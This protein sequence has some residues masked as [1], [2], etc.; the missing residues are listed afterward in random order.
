MK[1][2]N[3]IAGRIFWAI[4]ILGGAVLLTL[5]A[6]GIGLES[7]PVKILGSLLLVGVAVS[8][9]V[10]LRFFFAALPL[11]GIAAIW[12]A[13]LGYP[14]MN[15]WLVL[16]A[17]ALLGIALSILF[18]RKHDWK[19]HLHV[20]G[21]ADDDDDDSC[22]GCK[23]VTGSAGR[24]ST[25]TLDADETVDIESRFGEQ[26]KYI[27]SEHLKRVTLSASFAEVK[28]YFDQCKVHPD[29]LTI[30]VS[31][32]FCGI[33]LSLPKDWAVENRISVFAGAVNESGRE[34]APSA[35]KVTLVGS[36]NFG[37]IKVH[38]V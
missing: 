36:L 8:S 35:G 28:A 4:L 22:E 1:S 11:A 34:T 27:H 26:T 7:S 14:D 24:S 21:D 9:A 19:S 20:H 3:R 17:G 29:G 6:L 23:D 5:S 16:G 32:N 37:E 25:E 30:H 12:R 10:K 2:T 13:E 15:V 31:G 38:R 33:E 18:H